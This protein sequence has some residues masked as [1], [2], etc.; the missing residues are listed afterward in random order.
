MNQPTSTKETNFSLY[1]IENYKKEISQPFLEIVDK[2]TYL[3]IEYLKFSFENIK[4]KN[5]TYANFIITRGFNTII[6]VFRHL[7]YYTKNLDLTYFHCQKSFYFYVEF[8]GQ[9]LE[10]DKTFLQLT[11]RD[12]TIYVYK[13]TIYDVNNEYRK[14]QQT[15]SPET[16]KKLKIVNTYI[17]ICNMYVNKIMDNNDL[18]LEKNTLEYFEKTSIQ[19]NSLNFELENINILEKIIEKIFIYTKNTDDFFELNT[20]LYKKIYKSV[21]NIKKIWEKIVIENIIHD[22]SYNIYENNENSENSINNENNESN[23]IINKLIA[24]I[25]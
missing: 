13:K 8:V 5:K 24:I 9:I 18:S 4:I 2:L 11:S 22:T 3:I 17:N 7:L 20:L 19:F 10:D 25:S 16:D 1:N 15:I 21:Q 6:H 14:K 23:K 12:A